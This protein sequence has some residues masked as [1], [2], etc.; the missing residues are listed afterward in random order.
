MPSWSSDRFSSAS[1]QIIPKDSTPRI[2]AFLIS[3]PPGSAAPTRATGTIW[4]AATFGA[5]QMICRD[6]PPT[7][8]AQRESR[9][10]LGWRSTRSTRPVT[11]PAKSLPTVSTA[12]TSRPVMTSR[13]TS[14]S[15]DHGTSQYARSHE[16]GTLITMG[17]LAPSRANRP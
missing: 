5:P 10:A 8:T 15:T 9:S 4:P 2:F 17:R 1:E 7:S 11:N 3:I 12:S 14:S 16:R 6:S 13:S